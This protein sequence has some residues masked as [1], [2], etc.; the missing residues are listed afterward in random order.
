M[1]L[2]HIYDRL[3][4]TNAPSVRPVAAVVNGPE[5]RCD[6]AQTRLAGRNASN[7][8]SLALKPMASR[9]GYGMRLRSRI[10]SGKSASRSPASSP[11]SPWASRQ[12]SPDAPCK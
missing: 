12:R 8:E 10:T 2:T 5:A 9:V 1:C 3:A 6:V 7:R 4:L 11:L